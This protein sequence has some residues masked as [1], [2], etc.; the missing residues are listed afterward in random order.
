MKF[1]NVKDDYIRFIREYDNKVAVNKRE[2]RPYVGIILEVDGIKYYAPFTSPKPKHQKMRNGK[3]FRKIHDGK[4]GAINFNNMI[5]V[6]DEAVL[7]MDI[8][9]E[10]DE[11]YRRLLQN[12]YR[13]V[14]KD[15]DAIIK[16]ARNLRTLVLKDDSELTTYDRNIKTRCC[17]LALLESVYKNYK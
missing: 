16:T 10:P 12:Q 14:K 3:D 9:N 5:P 17:N 1:Y 8:D 6:P 4:Y 2:S 13:S 7:L 11:Q 15:T